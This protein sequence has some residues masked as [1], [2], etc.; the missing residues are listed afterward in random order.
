M[1]GR[2]NDKYRQTFVEINVKFPFNASRVCA[3]VVYLT[4]ISA[5][6]PLA[7]QATILYAV[8]LICGVDNSIV[9]ACKNE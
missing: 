2:L 8:K 5:H 6:I 1:L 9:M 3:E 4:V 7:F